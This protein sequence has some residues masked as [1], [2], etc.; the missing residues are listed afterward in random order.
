MLEGGQRDKFHLRRLN[1]SG[2]KNLKRAFT[3]SKTEAVANVPT[4]M[5]T[6]SNGCSSCWI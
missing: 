3:L 5:D 6:I 1:R 4:H 2:N